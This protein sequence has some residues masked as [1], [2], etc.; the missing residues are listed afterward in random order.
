MRPGS[1]RHTPGWRRSSECRHAGGPSVLGN[2]VHQTATTCKRGLANVFTPRTCCASAAYWPTRSP[3]RTPGSGPTRHQTS[4]HHGVSGRT[5]PHLTDFAGLQ[6]CAGAAA[7]YKREH[8]RRHACLPGSRGAADP[9]CGAECRSLRAGPGVAGVPDRRGEYPAGNNLASALARLSR[10]H[11]GY[12]LACHPCSRTLL[13]AMTSAEPAA[14]S[15]AE[16][17]APQL[18]ACPHEAG[19]GS[20]QTQ[21]YRPR[22]RPNRFRGGC[23]RTE[24][25]WRPVSRPRRP[26]G[27]AVPRWRSL[28][29]AGV[30]VAG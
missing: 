22:S 17:C 30:G 15:S 24:P 18:F 27:S 4:E 20:N 9:V 2:G 16:E 11:P 5:S 25:W 19:R 26:S 14:R 12:R 29:A 13:A 7:P 28:T 1:A 10:I 3:T 6:C 23:T 21:R 8:H